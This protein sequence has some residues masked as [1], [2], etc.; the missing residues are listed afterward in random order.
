MKGKVIKCVNNKGGKRPSPV[1]SGHQVTEGVKNRAK[2]VITNVN[3]DESTTVDLEVKFEIPLAQ[4]DFIA[5]R[6]MRFASELI[7]KRQI[8][9]QKYV[10]KTLGQG[11]I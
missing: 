2:I 11:Q 8:C 3:K 4:V 10:R 1:S 9:I 7:L 5:N 6:H